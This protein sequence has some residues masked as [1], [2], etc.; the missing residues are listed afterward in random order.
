MPP[1]NARR[2]KSS[3]PMWCLKT[4]SWNPLALG[5]TCPLNLHIKLSEP[6]E[7]VQKQ[8]SEPAPGTLST[9]ELKEVLN[10]WIP[11][12]LVGGLNQG[13]LE[14]KAPQSLLSGRH[15]RFHNPE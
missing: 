1:R 5:P 2:R 8:S 10:K 6:K 9:T 7:A 13:F 15:G 3:R 12:S 11:F 4:I 14:M